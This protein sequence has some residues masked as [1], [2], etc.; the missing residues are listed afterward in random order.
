M[1]FSIGHQPLGDDAMLKQRVQR[2]VVNA[3]TVSARSSSCS[4]LYGYDP[5]DP[6]A[7]V[8]GRLA[9]SLAAR[10]GRVLAH[11]NALRIVLLV[12]A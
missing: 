12:C 6:G 1:T 2:R 10:E 5:N 8:S 11:Q 7:G 3:V 4:S 9:N